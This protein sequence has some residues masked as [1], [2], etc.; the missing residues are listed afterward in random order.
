MDNRWIVSLGFVA[1]AALALLAG[2]A[3]GPAEKQCEPGQVVWEKGSD[4]A[5]DAPRWIRGGR[6]AYQEAGVRKADVPS[7]F[8]VFVG[9]SED[10]NNDRGARFDGVEDMLK[11]YAYWLQEELDE[12]LPQAARQAKATLPTIDTAL[13]AYN[14]V[15]YLPRENAAFL[16]A[17]WQA[18]GSVCDT[19]EPVYRVYALGL[20]DRETRRAHLLEAA[21]ETFKHSLIRAEVKEEVLRQFE[22]LARRL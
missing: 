9:V 15:I 3:T 13:G 4:P 7:K 17:V 8:L 14:A 20:F 10:K 1:A 19:G 16:R 18:K 5:Q 2:C 12:L 22:K 21:K 11:R 6:A